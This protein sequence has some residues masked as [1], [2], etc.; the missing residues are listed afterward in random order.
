M[1][2]VAPVIAKA[3]EGPFLTYPI[4]PGVTLPM[5]KPLN[6]TAV[7]GANVMIAEGYQL[8]II[9]PIIRGNPKPSIVWY[10]GDSIIQ[11]TQYLV[12]ENGT[13]VIDSVM[14][15]RDEGVY[16]CI[17]NTPD[18]GQDEASTTVIVPGKL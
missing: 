17:A 14:R 16:T 2:T 5:D 18:V 4:P 12:E 6:A 9:C 15:D 8:S 10:L 13:L 7:I 11:G 1:P 3:P